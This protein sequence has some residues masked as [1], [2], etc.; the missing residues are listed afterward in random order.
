MIDDLKKQIITQQKLLSSQ[1]NFSK[2]PTPPIQDKFFN[3][4]QKQEKMWLQYLL[5]QYRQR[6]AH[7]GTPSSH[8]PLLLIL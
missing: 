4:I 2:E 5:I 1:E 7:L 8:F 6:A 3:A